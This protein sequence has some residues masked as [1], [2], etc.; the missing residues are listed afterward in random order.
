MQGGDVK[1]AGRT[2]LATP[3]LVA[4][5]AGVAAL[6]VV[7]GTLRM[8]AI[9]RNALPFGDQW[10]EIVTG[11][12]IDWAWLTSQHVEH[13]ILFPRLVFWADRVFAQET[14]DLNEAVIVA[15]QCGLAAVLLRLAARAGLTAGVTRIWS[16]GIC[17][18][19]LFWAGQYQ[20][21]VWGFQVQFVGVVLAAAGTFATL[22]LVRRP[23]LALAG[24]VVIEA[25]GVYTLASGVL[26]PLLATLLAIIMRR[27]K[28][29]VAVL[30]AT[31][32][33][34]LASYLWGYHTPPESSDPLSA[35]RNAGSILLYLFT[36]LGAPIGNI[37]LL[38]APPAV[39]IGVSVA[40]GVLGVYAMCRVGATMLRPNAT[41]LPAQA[42]LLMTAA[43]VLG[44]L[45]IVA[46]GRLRF[47]I[48][49]AFAPRYA[50]PAVV[51]WCC[52][53]FLLASRASMDGWV[54]ATILRGALV[55]AA[56]MAFTESSN[57]AIAQDWVA[58][59][60]AATPAILAGVIDAEL[61]IRVYAI[62]ASG[63]VA[64][65]Q[66]ALYGPALRAQRT[67]V[68]A[69]PWASW[70]GSK[71]A[72]HVAGVDARLCGGALS[73]TR[74]VTT[75]PVPGYRVV[76]HAWRAGSGA[77]IDRLVITDTG[78]TI[79]GYGMGGVSLAA[80]TA[81]IGA[82]E[83]AAPGA[84]TAYALVGGYGCALAGKE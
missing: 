45:A 16:A 35:W 54:P 22:A 61:L 83:H 81:W 73:Q 26:I 30:A 27:P 49:S 28:W 11:R 75:Q 67:T 77:P 29:H 37:A 55:L 14:N 58:L 17:L 80:D 51:Y 63:E 78:G 10:G 3:R 2:R 59:R 40:A 65:S 43:F 7:A 47:G 32:L 8:V 44:M 82:F 20:N 72:D 31:A 48:T 34:L 46:A 66:L 53:T 19:L 56:L 5:L 42:A 25:I 60:R 52:L 57:V 69:D 12:R 18:S 4:A 41:M 39:G 74:R 70:L 62:P 79:V 84:V 71:L 21:F 15:I 64:G 76:G 24:A 6:W 36:V 68:F 9:C 23:G 33:L 1:T 38:H 13:R 50:S